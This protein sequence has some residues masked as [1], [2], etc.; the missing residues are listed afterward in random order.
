MDSTVLELIVIKKVLTIYNEKRESKVNR[1]DL[2]EMKKDF[3][4]F[5][6]FTIIKV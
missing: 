6:I 4:P 3:Q 2:V 5:L 1:L